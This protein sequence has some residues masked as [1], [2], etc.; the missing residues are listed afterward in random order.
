VKDPNN[1][2]ALH[3]MLVL[4]LVSQKD[5]SKKKKK[6]GKTNHRQNLENLNSNYGENYALKLIVQV[7]PNH[8]KH[9]ASNRGSPSKAH[10]LRSSDSLAP[11]VPRL[12]C[13]PSSTHIA[14]CHNTHLSQTGESL[15]HG[16]ATTP[17]PWRVV[18]SQ[19][20]ASSQKHT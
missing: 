1:P 3:H 9:L 11:S 19:S 20:P 12:W 8:L 17:S 2:K 10:G 13:Q 14:P 16:R 7:E 5:H 6:K 15:V 4:V 18:L